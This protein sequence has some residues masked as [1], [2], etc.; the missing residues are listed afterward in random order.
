MS[1]CLATSLQNTAGSNVGHILV[2]TL[3]TSHHVFFLNL[4]CFFS[5]PPTLRP[6]MAKSS[7]KRRR[8]HVSLQ[9][10]SH[11]THGGKVSFEANVPVRVLVI[12]FFEKNYVI[13]QQQW[14]RVNLPGHQIFCALASSRIK[15]FKWDTSL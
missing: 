6:S 9:K 15:C 14:P 10:N 12:V 7:R 3:L 13:K 11:S 4:Y 1:C 8:P 5:V 2:F